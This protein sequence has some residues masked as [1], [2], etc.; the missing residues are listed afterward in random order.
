VLAVLILG[1]GSIVEAFSAWLGVVI[2]VGAA[3]WLIYNASIWSPRSRLL[4][5]SAV[6]VLGLAVIGFKWY[7]G[8][9]QALHIHEDSTDV[10]SC[11]VVSFPTGGDCYRPTPQFLKSPASRAY[12]LVNMTIVNDGGDAI[13]SW[14]CDAS[15]NPYPVDDSEIRAH[16]QKIQADVKALADAGVGHLS[17]VGQFEKN[18][19]SC[20]TAPITPDQL[21]AYDQHRATLLYDFLVVLTN[22]GVT[23]REN[24]CGY[25]YNG[26]VIGCPAG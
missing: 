10:Y 22:N 1:L 4:A 8:I 25:N 13:I 2:T 24:F 23:R 9:Y 7:Q 21:I 6:V 15:Y 19:T 26:L 18:I 5:S 3:I 11:Q 20:R 14:Y 17:A 16:V 12:L